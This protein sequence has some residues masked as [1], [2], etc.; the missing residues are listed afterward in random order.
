MRHMHWTVLGA[1]A[2]VAMLTACTTTSPGRAEPAPTRSTETTATD[3]PPSTSGEAQPSGKPLPSDGAPKVKNP[4]DTSRFEQDPCLA[5]TD[6]Q[7]Q[8]LNLTGERTRDERPFGNACEW[9]NPETRGSADLYF[10]NKIGRG[11]S[12]TYWANKQGSYAFF[13]EL[14]EIEGFP[15]VAHGGS[16]D[17]T[18]GY[19][20]VEVGVSDMLAYQ[21]SGQLSRANVGKKDPCEMTTQAAALM[22]QTMKAGG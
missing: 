18:N 1:A 17:R 9:R 10:L 8:Q 6:A 11:L 7:V 12:G 21:L 5:L 2:A 20:Y 4:L 14:P 16:T 19:C 3:V 13:I 15:A 22:L